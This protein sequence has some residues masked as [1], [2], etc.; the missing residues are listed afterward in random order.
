[1]SASCSAIAAFSTYSCDGMLLV[2]CENM[3]PHF[4]MVV[5]NALAH[6]F[7]S[8]SIMLNWLFEGCS[9]VYCLPW[10]MFQVMGKWSVVYVIL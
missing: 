6:S 7:G 10:S 8:V 4:S 1:M 2:S 5:L 9:F 3:L